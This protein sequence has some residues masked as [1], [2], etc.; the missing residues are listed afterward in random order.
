MMVSP[1]RSRL[2]Q[3]HQAG[4]VFRRDIDVAHARF[5]GRAAV[6][7][8]HEHFGDLR[9]LRAL[10]GQRVFATAA[11]DDQDLHGQSI[12]AGNGACR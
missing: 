10:P 2:R 7:G 11:A 1:T 9:R 3:R 12:S 4:D 8:R 6:A 5:G